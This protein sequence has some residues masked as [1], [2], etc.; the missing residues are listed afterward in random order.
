MVVVG[1]QV[2]DSQ[3]KAKA[4]AARPPAL[5]PEFIMTLELIKN[6]W[7]LYTRATFSLI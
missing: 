3:Q 5:C 4:R 2:A 7:T 6:L 1:G